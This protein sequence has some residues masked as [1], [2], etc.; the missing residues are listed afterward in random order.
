VVVEQQAAIA[1]PELRVQRRI[2][3]GRQLLDGKAAFGKGV[4]QKIE[5]AANCRVIGRDAW[6]GAQRLEF[7]QASVEI[8]ADV[9]AEVGGSLNDRVLCSLVAAYR[10]WLRFPRRAGRESPPNRARKLTKRNLAHGV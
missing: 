9:R 7:T 8:G 4:A 6:N 3:R 5:T 2:A 10:L 1:F